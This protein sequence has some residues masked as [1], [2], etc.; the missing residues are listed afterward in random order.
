MELGA[1][2]VVAAEGGGE[3]RAVVAPGG[4][5]GLVFRAEGVGV[6]EIGVG[7][8]PEAGEDGVVAGEEDLVP[9]DMRDGQAGGGLEGLDEAVNPA[10][11][12]GLAVFEADIRH[13]LQADA[14]A[15]EGAL[16]V[17][18]RGFEGLDHAGDGAQSAGTVRKVADA[19]QDDA[20]CGGEAAGG[21]GDLDV[22]GA[23]GGCG[24]GARAGVEVA[25]AI[26]DKRNAGHERL[27]AG[28]AG[29]GN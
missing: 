27:L 19:G 7:P 17:E 18:D 21:G 20:V 3:G 14:D 29:C 15:E 26:V 23:A 1:E 25:G 13:Q 2:E 5:V 24:E 8:G 12:A 16:A 4:D 28:A 6:G 22:M 10:E 11:A 9:A